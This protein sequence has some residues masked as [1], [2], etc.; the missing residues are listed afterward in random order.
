M[1]M[2]TQAPEVLAATAWMRH[3]GYDSEPLGVDHVRDELR[4]YFY[5]EVPEGLIE[6]A[7]QYELDLQ[8]FREGTWRC[9]VEEFWVYDEMEPGWTPRAM[10]ERLLVD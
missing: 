4:W 6:L 3:K 10:V 1:N 5:F 9:Q 7:V 2:T 8:R